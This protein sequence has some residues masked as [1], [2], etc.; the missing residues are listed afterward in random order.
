V[1]FALCLAGWPVTNRAAAQSPVNLR[2]SVSEI[3]TPQNAALL[4]PVFIENLGQF[5]P[6]VR[7]QAKIGSQT[8]WL[9]NEGIV[10]DATRLADGEKVATTVP[11]PIGSTSA[12]GRTKL[13][14]RT[15]D[16]LVFTEDFV[17]AKC[18]SKVEGKRPRLGVYN[19]FQ[20]S[21]PTKWRTNVRG[22]AEVV[23]RDVWPGIDLRIYGNGSDLEQEFIV[24]RGGKLDHVQVAYRGIRGMSIAK[25]GTLEINTAFGTLRETQPRIYQQISDQRVSVDGRF[26][27]TSDRSYAFEVGLHKAEYALVIDPTLLY[28]TFLGGSAGNN[29]YGSNDE[30]ATSVAVDTSGNVYVTGYTLSTDFPTTP[31]AFQ[32]GP[33]TAQY[34]S[35]ITKLNASGSALVYST[36]LPLWYHI[37]TIATEI[38]VDASGRAFVTG[39]AGDGFPTTS[40]AAFPSC[41]VGNGFITVLNSGGNGLVYSSCLGFSPSVST[42]SSIAIDTRGRVAIGGRTPT[43]IPTTLNA[44]QRFHSGSTS[45][46]VMVFDTTASGLSSLVYSTHFGSTSSSSSAYVSIEGIATDSFGNIYV[47]GSAYEGIP[48]TAGA[49]QTSI[50]VGSNC[51]GAGQHAQ[52]CDDAFVAKFNPSASGSQSLI[53]STYLGG[54]SQDR[55]F[56]IAVDASGNAFVTGQTL[57]VFPV[58][59]GAF[60]TV[61]PTNFGGASDINFVTKLNAGGSNLVYSTYFR[62]TCTNFSVCSAAGIS[63]NAITVDTLGSAYIAGSVHTPLLPITPDAYQSTYSKPGCGTD[64]SSAFLTKLNPAGTGLIYSSYLGGVNHDVAT[65][66]TVDQIGDA[67]VAGHT[68]SPNFPVLV[69]FQSPMRG[70]G[71]AFVTKFG[72]GPPGALSISVIHPNHGGNSGMITSTIVGS[73]FHYGAATRLSCSGN[74]IPGTNIN[75]GPGGRVISTTFL[76]VGQ[77]PGSCSLSVVNPDGASTT[78][79]AAFTVEQGG[80]ADVQLDLTGRSGLRGGT[81]TIY[82]GMYT[83]RGSVDSGSFRVWISFPSFF[84]WS[85][86]SERPPGSV[87]QLNGT[88]YVGFDI[89]SVPAGSSGWIPVLLTPPNTPEFIH[90]PFTVQMWRAAQ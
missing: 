19:Y 23:Y 88:V 42:P 8:A 54:P 30:V 15:L 58:T 5:D 27:L 22:Y 25:D 75:V 77:L 12:L 11:K 63:S 44:F 47:T 45:G 70:T 49:F 2:P 21:D 36:Y 82:A 85:S 76:L 87:G 1:A 66:V 72:L 61:P 9:T 56:A 62:S 38:A 43:S 28:S 80:M 24:Q 52:V 35:F 81:P 59:P 20:G 57:G 55:G 14:S 79:P 65:A 33:G 4:T 41:S 64:C 50:N 71:D 17:G 60:Q 10:F 51:A 29:R 78:L 40:N 6:K 18:C 67:Y 7:F 13:E 73:G 32:I 48:T 68:A 86:L 34:S 53:Y 74:L 83:N 46:F 39:R 37:A 26:K 69:P 16:R 3:A 90:R 89:S 84:T 31:G